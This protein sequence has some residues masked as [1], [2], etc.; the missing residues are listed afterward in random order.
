MWPRPADHLFSSW[1]FSLSLHSLWTLPPAV[2]QHGG[3]AFL[4]AYAA[5]VAL[6]GAPL[7]LLEVHVLLSR[8]GCIVMST[9]RWQLANTQA[10]QPVFSSATSSPYW[11][12]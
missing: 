4:L 8:R 5:A 2:A 9:C 6:V 1:A 7:L 12:A 10:S 3:L 11:P